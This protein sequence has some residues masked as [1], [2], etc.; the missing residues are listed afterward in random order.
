M[1]NI[2]CL[3]FIFTNNRDALNLG[4]KD[5]RYIVL[6][7]EENLLEQEFYEDFHKWLEFD[8]R[9]EKIFYD[10]KYRDLKKRKF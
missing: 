6:F 10:L 9:A 4:K 7:H 2:Y 3:N 8:Q 5:A 1:H